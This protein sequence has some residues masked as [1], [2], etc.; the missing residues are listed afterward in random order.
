MLGVLISRL[1]ISWNNRFSS[2]NVGCCCDFLFTV[3]F[4]QD[5]AVGTSDCRLECLFSMYTSGARSSN[6]CIGLHNCPLKD[7]P[8]LV[9]RV[10]S[11]SLFSVEMLLVALWVA[12]TFPSFPSVGV[13][14]ERW[15]GEGW[16]FLTNCSSR[17]SYKLFV[18]GN[19]NRNQN[20]NH[21]A[22][23][24]NDQKWYL[25]HYILLAVLLRFQNK[26]VEKR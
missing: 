2:V 22:Q 5:T 11:L 15:S 14:V 18:R 12:L 6:G 13:K 19:R 1:W 16:V 7:A 9:S 21:V 3:V 8:L 26:S 25:L 10:L 23:F 4:F 24:G 20:R 17:F